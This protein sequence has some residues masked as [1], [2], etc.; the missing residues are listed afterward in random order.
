MGVYKKNK[1]KQ[2]N[3]FMGRS[4]MRNKLLQKEISDNILYSKIGNEETKKVSKQISVLDKTPLDD[5]LDNQLVINSVEVSRVFIQKNEIKEK[6]SLRDRNKGKDF[7][8]IQ[9]IVLPIPGRPFLLKHQDKV[10]IILHERE[11]APVKKKKKRKN[12]KKISFLMSGKSLIPINVR[13]PK[14]ESSRRKKVRPARKAPNGE[15]DVDNT[16]TANVDEENEQEEE[17]VMDTSEKEEDDEVE[18]SDVEDEEEDEADGDAESEEEEDRDDDG[19][20]EEDDEEDALDPAAEGEAPRNLQYMR[21]YEALGKKYKRLNVQE[22]LNKETVNKYELEHFVEWRKL[23]SVVEEEEGYTITPYEKNI[24]YWKQLWRV[25]EKSH[26]LF[27]II[28]ARNPMFFYCQGLEYYIRKVDPRKEFYVILNK[29][30][31]LNYEERKEWAAFFEKKNVK[32]IFFSALR[33]LYH[34]NKV[35]IQDLPLPVEVYTNGMSIPGGT[36]EKREDMSLAE[37]SSTLTERLPSEHMNLSTTMTYE[38]NKKEAAIDV[39]HGSL[40]YEERKNDQTDILSTNEMVSL[41]QKVKEE[42]RSEYHDIEIGDYSIP[43]FMVGF[44]GFPNVGKSSIINSL[45]G[46]KKVSVSR[47]PGKTKHF[48]T[49]PLK[50][51]G[52]SLC[53][54]PGLIFPSLVFSKYDLILN[55]V[56]SVDHYKGN[57]TDLVQILCNIIPHQLCEKYRIDKRLI[58]DIQLDAENGFE[59]RTHLYLDAT[60]FLSAFCS[61]RKYISGGKGGLLN[62]NFATRLIIRDFITGKLLYNFMPSYLACNAH[63]Y[64]SGPSP[65]ELLAASAMV[66]QDHFSQDPPEPEEILTTKRKFRY[67]QKKLIRGKNV[68]KHAS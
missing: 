55:G 36:Q 8:E 1:T 66:D 29:S 58:C 37:G 26:V 56:F 17:E 31:F 40:T 67:M 4:L 46:L 12:V 43:K 41:I 35:I 60:Q 7:L 52:F 33:E 25:I 13:S 54:C 15:V 6:K 20:D 22:V 18:E 28:D 24:E 19:D 50:R 42:K 57:L 9:N 68:M 38:E 48:Q 27:Y 5:Y 51:H 21:M 16:G 47:Q 10:N 23:L 63:V 32:F 2:N 53:D 45:V 61:S 39:G 49:I 64:R 44:I 14:G 3:N 30:D 59:K 11:N 34:Q 65:G 62:L